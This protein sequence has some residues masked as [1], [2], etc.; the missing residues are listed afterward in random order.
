MAIFNSNNQKPN[1]TEEG[2]LNFSQL[3]EK[4]A[5]ILAGII[6]IVG[7]ISAISAAATIWDVREEI[8]FLGFLINIAT[9]AIYAGATYLGCKLFSLLL[10]ALAGIHMNTRIS[11]ETLKAMAE[12][13]NK[14]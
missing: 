2:L 3:I 10:Q 1:P 8:D 14:E 7:V 6:G 9:T 11:A 5:L 13:E 12:K 4:V